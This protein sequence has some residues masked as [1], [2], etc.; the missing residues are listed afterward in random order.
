MFILIFLSKIDAR[1]LSK[2]AMSGT[3]P[4]SEPAQDLSVIS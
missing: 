3:R 4:A 2:R 1:F